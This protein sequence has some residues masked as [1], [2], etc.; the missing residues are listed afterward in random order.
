MPETLCD[1]KRPIVIRPSPDKRRWMLSG[2]NMPWRRQATRC[3]GAARV[4]S[5]T[6]SAA[7][8]VG[9]F[10]LL[11]MAPSPGAPVLVQDDEQPALPD[12]G[13]VVAAFFSARQWLNAF[14]VPSLDDAAARLPISGASG[15]CVHLR[16]SGR[17]IGRGMMAPTLDIDDS[18]MLRRAMGRAMSQALGDEAVSRLPDELRDEIGTSLVL[19]L[20][21]AGKPEPMIA[22]SFQ[23]IARRIEP[24]VEGV[25][26]R[27]GHRWVM[28]FPS[29]LLATDSAELT[30]M[31]LRVLAQDLGVNVT[32][33]ETLTR[34]HQVSIYRFR[35]SHLVQV[36][37]DQLPFETFRGDRIVALHEVTRDSVDAAAGALV[38]HIQQR[39]EAA[40]SIGDHVRVLMRQ[41]DE[42]A[43]VLISEGLQGDRLPI[44]LGDYRPIADRFDPFEARPFDQALVAFAL[45]RYA[46]RSD[47]DTAANGAAARMAE[48]IVQHLLHGEGD[49]ETSHN[50]TVRAAALFAVDQ[51]LAVPAEIRHHDTGGNYRAIPKQT[52]AQWG[53]TLAE[54]LLHELSVV[55]SSEDRLATPID[56]HSFALIA[57][58]MARRMAGQGDGVQDVGSVDVVRQALDAL[59]RHTPPG[60]DVALLPWIGWAERDL[61]SITGEEIAHV[62]RLRELGE[63]LREVQVRDTARAPRDLHGGFV[64]AGQRRPNAQSIRPAVWLCA[65]LH[66]RDLTP[67]DARRDHEESVR[68]AM[69]FILQ[70]TVRESRVWSVRN[71]DRAIGGVRNAPWD[72]DQPLAAQAMALLALIDARTAVVPAQQP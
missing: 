18:L 65:A 44:M 42:E 15:V 13:D 48:R 38:H 69:R 37:P 22:R 63:M 45:A 23:Q 34:Q 32:D 68:A 35:T 56:P 47:G 30:A 53:E 54:S 25:A 10:V 4:I 27:R 72:I 41:H 59:W 9:M 67:P 24:G 49:G 2:I 26:M 19:E 71:R 52:L 70:L 1:R 16:H 51:L 58:A 28:L 31:R 17:V 66:E 62:D 21:V 50:S 46:S 39:I 12:A 40:D 8:I 36:A 29:Q 11:P 57:G 6:V 14:D 60:R 61:A 5:R 7:L 33:L 20:E 64:L 43:E 3:G 55:V